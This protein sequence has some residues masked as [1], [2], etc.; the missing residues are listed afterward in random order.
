MLLD[1]VLAHSG[2]CV[3][4]LP[5]NHHGDHFGTAIELR[6]DLLGINTTSDFLISP[7]HFQISK[8]I[9]ETI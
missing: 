6:A 3:G 9:C 7:T 8:M 1:Y 5:S 2:H 4:V